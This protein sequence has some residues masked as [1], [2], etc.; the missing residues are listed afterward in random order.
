MFDL[1]FNSKDLQLVCHS[2]KRV[3]GERV[4]RALQ[5]RGVRDHFILFSSGTTS[6][7][8]KGY[9]LSR[10]ALLSNAKAVN[11]HFGLTPDDVW[12]LSIPYYHVGGL[13]VVA[14]AFALGSRLVDLGNWVPLTW[15]NTL[16]LEGVTITTVVPTQIYDLVQQKLR[17]PN[18]L[19][20]LVVGG[21]FLPQELEKR[22]LDLG[23]PIIRTFGMTEV[24]SQ[25]AS[26]KAPGG[27][28][29]VLPIHQIKTDPEGRLLVKSDSLFTLEF[30]CKESLELRFSFDLIDEDGF[31]PTQD[32][33][34]W[35]GMNFSHLGRFDDQIK[36]SGKLVGLLELKDRLAEFALANGLY[37]KIELILEEDER[38]GKKIVILHQT[39]IPEDAVREIFHPLRVHFKTVEFFQRTDLGKLKQP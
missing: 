8:L 6:K 16:E 28:L 14:R 10:E 13:S 9:A 23:W 17:A 38:L 24:C 19:R 26:A 30:K 39:D 1:D 12:G 31:Y 4:L 2:S 7:D 34:L 37:E 15:R 33:V 21:D 18:C 32:R 27:V 20:F 29:S 25:L 3:A 5:E 36:S 35:D 11:A 22:A